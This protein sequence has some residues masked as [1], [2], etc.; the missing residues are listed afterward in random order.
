MIYYNTRLMENSI[1]SDS[2]GQL[3]D[4]IKSVATYGVCAEDAWPYS[5]IAANVEGIFPPD[6]PAVTRPPAAAYEG[7]SAAKAI[8]YH[9]ITQDLQHMKACLV[10]GFPFVLGFTV[11]SSMFDAEGNPV[12]V[13]PM[14]KPEDAVE[15]GHAVVAV[16]YDDEKEQ[17]T[18][19]NSWGE[20][21]QD[22]GYF[23]IPYGYLMD[24]TLSS[25]FWTIRKVAPT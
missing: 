13:L 9:A 4:A 18:I 3:R 16:G 11:Y 20:E 23:Y 24:S 1:E 5:D 14:P 8:S 19:R 15:G 10:E 17:F 25:D 22:K 21:V 2:G 7:A 6:C 12:T